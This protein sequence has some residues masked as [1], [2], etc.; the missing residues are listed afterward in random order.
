MMKNCLYA[1]TLV[2]MMPLASAKIL[3]SIDA[4]AGYGFYGLSEDAALAGNTFDLDS[5]DTNTGSAP[6]N[7]GMSAQNGLYGWAKIGL[8]LLPDVKLKY[9]SLVAEGSNNVNINVPVFGEDFNMTG[10]VESSFDLSYLDFILTLGLPLPLVDVDFGV[11]ARSMLGGFSAT[12]TVAGE[13]E[14]IDAPFSISDSG[15]P[16]ILPMGYLS[17]AASIPVSGIKLAAEVSTLPLGDTSFTDW[18]VKGI[19]YFPLPTNMLVKFGL[20][21]GYSSFDMTIGDSTLGLDTSDLASTVEMSGGFLGLT[22]HF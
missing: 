21:A 1:I 9:Q 4:G 17:A 19:W 15:T 22:A 16:L 11:N 10:E 8:P 7:L 2:A 3:L 20:E 6:Y 18:N 5:S 13:E 14:T 12:G